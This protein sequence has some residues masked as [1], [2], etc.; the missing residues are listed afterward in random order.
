MGFTIAENLFVRNINVAIPNTYHTF[1]GACFIRKNGLLYDLASKYCIK[2]NKDAPGNLSE[3]VVTLT[4]EIF[5]DLPLEKLYANVKARFVGL[6][7][8]ND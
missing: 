1:Q 8:Q 2:T 7:I 6:S 5:P 4:S 3:E